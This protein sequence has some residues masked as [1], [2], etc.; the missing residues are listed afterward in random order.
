VAKLKAS[1]NPVIS[2]RVVIARPE[3]SAGSIF[4]FLRAR[5]KV[6]VR[7]AMKR[8]ENSFWIFSTS[9]SLKGIPE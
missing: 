1:K 7:A 4:D 3:A 6:A 2:V 9:G 5:G 8:M